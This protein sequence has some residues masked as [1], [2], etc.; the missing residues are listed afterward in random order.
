MDEI[1]ATYERFRHLDSIIEDLDGSS[2][3][4][5]QL[6]HDLWRAVRMAAKEEL[7]GEDPRK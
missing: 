2:N 6:A 7:A 1:V 4:I 5:Y 3:P